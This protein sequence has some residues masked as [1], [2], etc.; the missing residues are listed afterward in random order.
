MVK[1][2]KGERLSRGYV[3]PWIGRM[4]DRDGERGRR[5]GMKKEKEGEVVVR[6]GERVDVDGG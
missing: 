4:E 3:L 2:W 6:S 1:L 5:K